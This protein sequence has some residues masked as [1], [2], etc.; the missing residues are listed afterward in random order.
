MS[1]Q[2]GDQMIQSYGNPERRIVMA[3]NKN[4]EEKATVANCK[5]VRLRSEPVTKDDNVLKVLEANTKVTVLD[6]S[7]PKWTKVKFGKTTGWIM[8][9]YLQM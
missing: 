4:N 8:R 7:N 1:L 9:E 2:I 6:G 5:R 3:K